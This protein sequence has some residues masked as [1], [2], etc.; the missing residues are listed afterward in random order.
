[1]LEGID[2]LA[3]GTFQALHSY[4]PNDIEWDARFFPCTTSTTA[5]DTT[6]VDLTLFHSTKST[7]PEISEEDDTGKNDE[8]A[9]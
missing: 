7:L 9:F 8:E 3:P 2:L 4:M 1:M 5:L 6:C